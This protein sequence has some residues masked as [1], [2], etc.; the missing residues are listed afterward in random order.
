MPASTAEGIANGFVARLENAFERVA[1]FHDIGKIAVPGLI[2]LKPGC[3]TEAELAVVRQ[4]TIY[5]VEVTRD[6][7]FLSTETRQVIRNHHER[8]DGRGYPNPELVGAF[9][10]LLARPA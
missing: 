9:L 3:L 2:L 10:Y 6:T 5:G 1:Y 7:A 8:W 4:H